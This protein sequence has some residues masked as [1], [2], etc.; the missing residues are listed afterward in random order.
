MISTATALFA[1]PWLDAATK[2]LG[3][4]NKT[5]NGFTFWGITKPSRKTRD[6]LESLNRSVAR[7]LGH[8]HVSTTHKH[9]TKAGVAK[10]ATQERALRVIGG[11]R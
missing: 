11:G 1:L 10:Q 7:A 6:P 3:L 8:E 4:A 9:Y 2:D 5:Q